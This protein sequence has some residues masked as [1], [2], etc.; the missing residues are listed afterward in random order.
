MN[1]EDLREFCLS[2]TGA[3]EGLPFD[4]NTLVFFVKKKMFCLV[5]I[6]DC[7][8]ITL[9][10][11]PDKAIELRELY[12]E[13]TPGYYMNK[14]HWNSVRIDSMLSDQLIKEWITDS[15]NLVIE[16]LPKKLRQELS[17]ENPN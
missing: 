2:F 9:K 5:N 17:L 7:Q 4:D 10:C 13:V 12:Q 11:A 16:R 8:Y 6:F 3:E 15:Y 1:L 14:K